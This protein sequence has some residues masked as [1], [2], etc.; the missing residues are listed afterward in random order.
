[1]IVQEWDRK[2]LLGSIKKD[3]NCNYLYEF[4]SGSFPLIG[5]VCG[6][7]FRIATT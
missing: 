6:K 5:N 2:G 7:A 3:S 4:R 1:M